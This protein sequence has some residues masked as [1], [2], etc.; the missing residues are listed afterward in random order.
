MK[1]RLDR[2]GNQ[3]LSLASQLE[4]IQFS[5]GASEGDSKALRTYYLQLKGMA[6]GL[7]RV[8]FLW[9]EEVQDA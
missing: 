4:E 9:G 6:S 1:D 5:E 8:A 3:L 2:I 7:A